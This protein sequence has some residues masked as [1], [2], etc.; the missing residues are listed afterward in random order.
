MG[1]GDIPLVQIERICAY[2][3]KEFIATHPSQ[4][5]CKGPHYRKCEACGKE[6][7][8][9]IPANIADARKTCSRECANALRFKNGNPGANSEVRRK[10]AETYK[11]RTGY[12]HPM[13][14]PEVVDK[15]R[16]TNLDNHDGVY[17]QTTQEY[18]DKTIQTNVEKYGVEWHTQNAEVRNKIEKSVQDKYGVEN[19]SQLP[20]VKAKIRDT[21]EQHTGYDHY[22]HNPE[23]MQSVQQTNMD[24]YGVP[25]AVSAP[26][27]REKS[28]NTMLDRYGVEN[29]LQDPKILDKVHKTT[30]QR[31]GNRVY[32]LTEE[33][34]KKSR[35]KMLERYGEPKFSMTSDWKSTMMRDPSK[36]RT[37]C[38]FIRS[39]EDALAYL[40]HY[41]HIPTWNEVCRDLGVTTS[42]VAYW[43]DKFGIQDKV[44]YTLSAMEDD[45]YAFIKRVCPE[46]EIRRH[47]R[48]LVTN[49]ELDIYIPK[50]HLGIECD[51]TYTHNSSFPT[52][53]SKLPMSPK[54]HYLKNKLF[55]ERGVFVFHIFGYEWEHKRPIIESMLRSL[56][57]CNEHKIYARQCEIKEV[58]YSDSKEFLN[59]NHRQG[60]SRSNVR[61]GLYRDEQLVSLMTFS[62]TRALIGGRDEGTWELL[63][64]CSKLNTTVIGAA[65]RLFK[66][67]IS[68][69]PEVCKIRSFSDMAHTR[70]T[71]YETLGFHLSHESAPGY[72][73][74]N[75]NTDVAYHRMNAAKANIQAFL[76]ESDID[77]SKTEKQIMESHGFAQVFDCGTKVWGWN[78]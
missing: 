30:E 8:F 49:R 34:K 29:A 6:F 37:W 20:E 47:C 73:W 18:R 41:D 51:P 62:K 72:V 11:A 66:Y 32:L 35:D 76:G 57:S 3:G 5:Y 15:V 48:N 43:L 27:V 64:F 12:D 26:Q 68:S 1:R 60:N 13:H 33:G 58:S 24:K 55:A 38:R 44:K 4:K 14:N 25:W 56:V 39:K 40:D 77:L 10:M 53:W 63:R 59:T 61:I 71:L 70:G 69:N 36:L 67:F 17:A 2:C 52:V 19:V 21:Y 42:T 16:R 75:I 7:E 23:A 74:V 45:V 31:Y 28:Q 78:R 22:T 50:F 46:L 54:Y 65:S 9:K